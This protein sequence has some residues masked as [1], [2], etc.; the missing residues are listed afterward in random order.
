MPVD[1]TTSSGLRRTHTKMMDDH[2]V[3]L[4]GGL[5]GDRI[6][7]LMFDGV[8]QVSTKKRLIGWWYLVPIALF[9]LACAGF[10]YGAFSAFHADRPQYLISSIVLAAAP[11]L[12]L[13]RWLLRRRL[14]LTFRY[15]DGTVR[16]T[17][18]GGRHAK[19]RRWLDELQTR[20]QAHA[21]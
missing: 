17:V 20:L 12:I 6:N 2:I 4:R 18:I 9:L 13:L 10:G 15:A 1:F 21:A 8:T 7:R 11:V 3:A 14:R 19:V 5:A 16:T